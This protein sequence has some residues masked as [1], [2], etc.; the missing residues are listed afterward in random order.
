LEAVSNPAEASTPAS[1]A[2]DVGR[3]LER[4]EIS[5]GGMGRILLAFDERIVGGPV[6]LRFGLT[7]KRGGFLEGSAAKLAM[8]AQSAKDK[9]G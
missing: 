5:R 4:E 7:L 2:L 6:C 1:D 8:F 9:I 3:Y